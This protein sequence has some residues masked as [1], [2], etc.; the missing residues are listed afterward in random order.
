MY[1]CALGR[2]TEGKE[3]VYLIGPE[4]ARTCGNEKDIFTFMAGSKMFANATLRV[5]D[6]VI[7]I[8]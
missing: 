8:T 5:K 3:P 1:M 7:G 6:Y 2:D 4:F